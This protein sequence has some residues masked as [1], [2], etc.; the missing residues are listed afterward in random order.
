MFFDRPGM[1]SCALL[2][3]VIALFAMTGCK[4]KA[5]SSQ[6]AVAPLAAPAPAVADREV[7]FVKS[8]YAY[9]DPMIHGKDGSFETALKQKPEVFDGPL[10]AA[11][12]NDRAIQAKSTDGI[13]GL[14]ADPFGYGQDP[15]SVTGVMV[16]GATA[17]RVHVETSFQGT[18]NGALDMQVRCADRCQLVNVF[19]PDRENVPAHDLLG[20]LKTM[21]PGK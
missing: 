11:L 21:H 2:V 18:K 4:G 13:T 14:D 15:D 19:Y 17:D 10:L 12:K 7:E 3:S 1:P 8:F 16:N 6:A 5:A 20:E 9:Y